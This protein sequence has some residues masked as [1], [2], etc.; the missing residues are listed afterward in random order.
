MLVSRRPGFGEPPEARSYSPSMLFRW[1]PVP[2][3]MTPEPEPVE[4]VSA[5]AF[6]AAST[7]EMCVVPPYGRGLGD[8]RR[9]RG[10]P[11][12]ARP[13]GA[14]RRA[15][16]APARRGGD[17]RG[18]GR[19]AHASARA[20]PRPAPRPH[21]RGA[22]VR[23]RARQALEQR[24]AVEDQNAAGRGRRVRDDLVPAVPHAQRPPPDDAIGREILRAS[25]CRRRRATVRTIASR[26]LAAVQRRGALA[27]RSARACRRDR[28]AGARRPRRAVSRRARCRGGGPRRCA[29]GSG[30]GSRADEPGAASPRR[31]H[32]RAR[33]PGRAARAT[34]APRTRGAAP[35]APPPRPERRTTARR[36][37]RPAS[38]ARRLRTRRRSRAS[39]R[40][41]AGSCPVPGRRDEEVR[42]PLRSA[43]GRVHERETARSRPGQRA[44]GDPGANAAA[45][46]ASTAFP[47]SSSTRAPACVVSGCPAATAPLI[48]RS[49]LPMT[50]P[51]DAHRSRHLHAFGNALDARL[52]VAIVNATA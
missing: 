35:R 4:H 46:H 1:I 8:A 43:V 17:L 31:R 42:E 26:E 36:S 11:R 20:S 3:T 22:V 24:Q 51:M 18:T 52:R 29:A 2:G 9:P 45:T 10:D 16:P 50:F 48:L 7:T 27:R 14:R 13:R 5:A 12:H 33:P 28:V 21:R 39:R 15:A 6:P 34:A 23:P 38:P 40:P 47:P 25:G 41:G 32:A 49:R 37:E 19:R 30:R 44:L